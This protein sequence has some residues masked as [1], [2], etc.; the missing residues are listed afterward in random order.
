MRPTTSTALVLYRKEPEQ[1]PEEQLAQQVMDILDVKTACVLR[2]SNYHLMSE[3]AKRYLCETLMGVTLCK[4]P[5]RDNN[6]DLCFILSK[7]VLL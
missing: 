1:T 3:Q 7:E 6:D 5:A 4:V 2:V